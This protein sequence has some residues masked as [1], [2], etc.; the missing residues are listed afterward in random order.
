[1]LSFFND[2]ISSANKK[3]YT[4]NEFADIHNVKINFVEWLWYEVFEDTKGNIR[5]H[6]SKNRQHYGQMKKVQRTNNDQQNIRLYK[7]KDRVTW[8]P[9]L[10]VHFKIIGI[11]LLWIKL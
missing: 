11:K 4:F 9:L 8:T 3:M 1:M 2:F 5:I 10:L 6:I 7:T